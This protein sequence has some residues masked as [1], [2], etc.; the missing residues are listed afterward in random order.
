MPAVIITTIEENIAI[1][2]FTDCVP[3]TA[4][5]AQKPG[6]AMAVALPGASAVI[7][8]YRAVH[9]GR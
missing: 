4:M 8:M 6:R 5:V 7:F 9:P 1:C 2:R 3:S